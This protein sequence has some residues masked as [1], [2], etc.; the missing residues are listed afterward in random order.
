MT[1]HEYDMLI[2]GGG[3]A[4]LACAC[5]L[6][7][8]LRNRRPTVRIGVIESQAPRPLAVDADT[9]LRVLAIAPAT[10]A[11]LEACG[12]WQLLPEGRASPYERMRV[13]Q[14]D[15]T[16]SGSGSIGFDAADSGLP[17]LGSHCRARLVAPEP[18]AGPGRRP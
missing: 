4:G 10:R 17:E 16:V 5:L 3:V 15:S 7:K 2:V 18:V 8:Y 14:A 6:R 1:D 11:I 12:A 9:G 13:W